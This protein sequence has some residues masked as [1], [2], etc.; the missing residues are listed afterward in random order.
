MYTPIKDTKNPLKKLPYHLR[1]ELASFVDNNANKY[2]TEPARDRAFAFARSVVS[3]LNVPY[4]I[5]NY[6]DKAGAARLK[7]HGLKRAMKFIDDRSA[8]IVASFGLLPE[9]WYRVD[10]EYKRVRLADE[11]TGRARLHLELALKAGKRPLEALEEINEFTGLSLW[12]PHFEPKKRDSDDDVYLSL[13]TRACDDAVW[14]RAINQ[15]VTIAFESARRAAG[16]V[17]PHVSPYASFTTCQWLKDRKKK[18]LDWLDSMAIE[19]E[20]GET[21]ELKDVHDASVSNP[22]NRR[23]ELMTQLRGCQEYADSNDHVALMATLTAAGRYHRLKKHGKY[24]V[25]NPNWNGANP[26]DAHEW[27]KTS[28]QRFRAAADRDK[29]TYYG[30]RVV[31]PHVDGTPHWHGVFFVPRDQ[32]SAF[33]ELLTFYQHQRDSDELFTDDGTAK[34]KAM[35]ARVKIE[36]IDRNKGDAVAYIAKYISKNIDAH[37]LEGKKD[38]DSNLVD[39]VET[40]TNVTA[41]SRAFCF[42]QFQFQKTPSVTVWRELRRIKEAQEFCL[43]EKIRL[44]ADCG[45][46]ASYFNWMGGHR[47]KQRNRP[48]KLFHE[49]S[50]NHY[51]ELVKK[52][53]GLTGVGITVLT[54]E[55]KWTLVKKTDESK[56]EATNIV[57]AITRRAAIVAK[58]NNKVTRILGS[59]GFLGFKSLGTAESG[60][61]RFPWTSVNNC[62]QGAIPQENTCVP[63]IE[64]SNQ[65]VTMNIES[66]VSAKDVEIDSVPLVW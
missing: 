63:D 56:G 66:V 17:S 41:W 1:C 52:T 61:S 53:V 43:F 34:L 49:R 26:I 44:A 51:Q 8:H 30:M 40:V 47:L 4:D 24:F 15:K 59:L 48:I 58:E 10:T 18:Q 20:C 7:Q 23:H 45:C 27:L 5:K 13:I 11:L 28:W 65:T 25:E 22:A 60:G 32:V 39:L 54:R 12:V 33:I 35:V 38:L 6:L 37:K 29:L 55:K 64:T 31:E 42:R 9:P 50:E 36:E 46:F 62:T 21:L 16:M 3:K 14:L 19:S 57:R 2:N